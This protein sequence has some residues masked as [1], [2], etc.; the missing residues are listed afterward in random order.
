MFKQ[1]LKLDKY[2]PLVL[3]LSV[4]TML[5]APL[6]AEDLEEDFDFDNLERVENSRVG[7][8]YIDPEADWAVFKRVAVLEPYVSFRSNWQRDVNRSRTRNVRDSDMERIRADVA[9][10]FTQVFKDRLTEAG[11]AVSESGDEGCAR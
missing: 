7:M 10:V 8:A 9:A 11:Y 3:L 4:L 6:Q 5:A 2:M 1:A